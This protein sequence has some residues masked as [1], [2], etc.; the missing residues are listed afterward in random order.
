MGDVEGRSMRAVVALAVAIAACSS[1]GGTS[2]PT[3]TTTTT[4]APQYTPVFVKGP[5]NDEV[6]QDPRIECGTLTVPEDRSKPAGHQVV[7]PVAIVH[8]TDPQPAPDPVVYFSGGPGFPGLT[9]VQGFLDKNYTG[10]RDAILFDQRGTGRA[11][12][13]LTCPEMYDAN[14]QISAEGRPAFAH[15]SQVLEAALTACRDRL[16]ASGVDLNQYNTSVVADDVADLRIAMGIAEWNLFGVSYGTTV[17]LQTMRA[18]PDGI[19][20]VV[21]DSVFPTDA[22]WNATQAV[23]D[24]ERVRRVFV[25]GCA[26]DA[27]CN[28]RYPNLDAD[29]DAATAALDADPHVSTFQDPT[30]NRTDP[31]VVDGAT[32]VSGFF[33]AMYDSNLIPQLPSII[34]QVKAGTA[35]PLLDA[36]VQQ[37]GPQINGAAEAQKDAVNC[38][39]RAVSVGKDD[40]PALLAKHPDY[41]RYVLGYGA[42]R[43]ID[44][45]PAPS[46]FSDP[47]RSDLP[48]LVL[49]DEYD[50]V[51]PP[52]QSRRAANTLT[53]STFVLFPGLGHGAVFSDR[54][55]PATIFRSFLTAPTAPVDTSCV[56]TMG[57]P[58]WNVG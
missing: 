20:S 31:F 37:L 41:T 52:E 55:C 19:R 44:V 25:Q 29:I 4:T 27:A 33:N 17:A 28:A 15:A 42:C 58:R 13:A 8:T 43:V 34:E 5:C 7:L 32:A 35:G 51:T 11:Q 57:P 12:P 3:T 40:I 39:D 47:V 45:A 6:P 54:E 10:N 36:L 56:S 53:H 21:I 30:A 1:G 26:A 48:T 22:P 14:A 24:F 16:R 23:A 2:A 9:E 18:H 46:G 38:S 50:P 49:A